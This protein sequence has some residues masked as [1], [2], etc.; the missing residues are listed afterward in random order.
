[1]SRH[2]R[3]FLLRGPSLIILGGFALAFLS[4]LGTVAGIWSSREIA[5]REWE[6]RLTSVARMLL[7]HADQSFTAADLVLQGVADKVHEYSSLD[8]EDMQWA[9]RS[10]YMFD[11]LRESA[12]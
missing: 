10:R 5:L 11:L 7:A 1:M 6:N 2:R 3:P 9:F 8:A 12:R 4:A